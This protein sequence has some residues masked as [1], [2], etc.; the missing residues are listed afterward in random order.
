VRIAIVGCGYVADFYMTTLTNH[1]ALV[2]AG[3]HDRD[4]AR[5]SHFA[6]FHHTRDYG[7]LEALLA[8]QSVDLIVNLTNPRSHYEV[9]RAALEAGKHLYSEK[10]LATEWPQAVELVELASRRGLRIGSAP[11]TVLGEAAQTVWRAVRERRIGDVRLVYAELDD[12]MVHLENFRSWKSASGIPWPAKDEF[13]IGCTLEHAG[14]YLSW[15]AAM[16]GPAESVTAFASAQL[17][18]KGVPNLGPPDAP[19]F[20]VGCIRF[21]SGVAARITCSIIGAHDHTL[22]LFGDKGTLVVK[23]A[24]D[25]GSPVLLQKW[26]PFTFRAERRSPALAHVAVG[27]RRIPLVRPPRFRSKGPGARPI[28]FCRGI[29]EL[30]DAVRENRPARLSGDFS[31]HITEM[32]LTLHA[33]RE[34]GSPRRM[35]TT[36]APM[37]PMPW[38]VS[39]E[40]RG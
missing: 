12:G 3:V 11:C 1:A 17:P 26:T 13:E 8:D 30:A 39:G 31:L 5:A 16:F 18:D 2:L 19:D 36:F 40:R 27:P 23:E 22:R 28:D 29:A 20:S 21:A 32:A 9:S 37:E 6:R 25:F 35:T 14:Y 7:S 15:L 10:P 33:P 38:A 34:M 4:P 24:W